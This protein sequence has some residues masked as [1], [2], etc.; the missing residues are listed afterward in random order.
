MKKTAVI[1]GASRGIGAAIASKLAEEG[2]DLSLCCRNNNGFLEDL[3]QRLRSDH[4][5]EVHCF[6]GDISD[7]DFC[8]TLLS[9]FETPDVL[10]NN[11]GISHIGL[12]QD[13]TDKEWQHIMNVDLNG[14]FYL[15]RAAIPLMLK[16][17]SGRIVNISSVWGRVGASMEVAYSAAKGGI[18]AMT[19]AL[20]RELAP[21]GISVNALACGFIDT[22]MNAHLS[23]E[24]KKN[25]YEQIPAGRPGTPE[26]VA[27][28]V[29]LLLKAP[30]YLTGQVISFDGGWT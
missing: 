24:E 20:S 10:V 17:H 26:E 14:A 7:P 8:N 21:S 22:E 15:S 23:D 27:E 25:L 6:F 1:S 2:Y 4:P 12:L 28:C 9:P 30:I 29:S 18:D 13:M 16:R 19:R 11:A 5:V 3:A